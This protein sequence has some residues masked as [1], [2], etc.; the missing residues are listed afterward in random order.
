[1]KIEE[2]L[3]IK[4]VLKNI[5][6]G[7]EFETS[8]EDEQ[9][10]FTVSDEPTLVNYVFKYYF[11]IKE[12]FGDDDSAVATLDVIITDFTVDGVDMMPGWKEIGYNQDVW[13]IRNVE[14]KIHEEISGYIP[15]SIYLNFYSEDEL[16]NLPSDQKNL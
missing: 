1:M 2:N 3:K 10:D 9:Y 16:K 12:V 4:N 7:Q 15:V 8:F 11:K 14:E 5:Y 6:E 13:Y